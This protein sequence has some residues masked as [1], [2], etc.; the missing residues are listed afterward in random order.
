MVLVYAGRMRVRMLYFGVL[1]ELFGTAEEEMEA[2]AG[3]TV[4]SLLRILGERTSNLK[5]ETRI[6]QSTA[7]AVNREYSSHGA[8]LRDGDEVALL[9]PVSGGCCAY[10]EKLAS[11][12]TAR[13]AK[14]SLRSRRLGLNETGRPC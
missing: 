1:K 3:T 8:V 6:W 11:L 14:S 5:M 9:P 7:V 2:P 13:T 10:G 12:G 4:G